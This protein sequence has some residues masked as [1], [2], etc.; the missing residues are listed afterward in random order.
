MPGGWRVPWEQPWPPAAPLEPA[1][2]LAFPPRPRGVSQVPSPNCSRSPA[3]RRPRR[4]AAPTT[5]SAAPRAPPAPPAAWPDPPGHPRACPASGHG[6]GGPSPDPLSCF[7][8]PNLRPSPVGASVTHSVNALAP[9]GQPM[10]GRGEAERA[11]IAKA[12]PP[13]LPIKWGQAG[14]AEVGALRPCPAALLHP[15]KKAA[16][17]IGSSKRF[18][19]SVVGGRWADPPPPSSTSNLQTVINNN[20]NLSYIKLALL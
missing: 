18:I 5:A 20:K 9:Q 19:G 17:T 4:A 14:E 8:T 1:L 12:P 3:R 2:P 16:G 13:R 15:P 7:F 6:L 10:L 11:A